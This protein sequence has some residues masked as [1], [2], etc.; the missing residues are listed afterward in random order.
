MEPICT[1][2]CDDCGEFPILDKELVSI[3]KLRDE[4]T[5]VTLCIYCERAVIADIDKETLKDLLYKGIIMF[6]WME[7]A[8]ENGRNS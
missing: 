5:A 2:R 4:Y 3:F 6:D 1:V 7:D 8:N